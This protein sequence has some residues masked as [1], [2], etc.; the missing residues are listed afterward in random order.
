[1]PFKEVFLFLGTG[2]PGARLEGVGV[3]GRLFADHRLAEAGGGRVT[4]DRRLGGSS[5][6]PLFVRLALQQPVPLLCLAGF[7]LD[8]LSV[9]LVLQQLLTDRPGRW[10]EEEE[11]VSY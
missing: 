11:V 6:Q 1:M 5:H 2:P 8:L 7:M 9:A 3:A 10:E 4:F